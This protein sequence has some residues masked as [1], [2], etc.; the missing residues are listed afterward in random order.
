MKFKL[1]DIVTTIGNAGDDIP[2]V[3]I[4]KGVDGADWVLLS[5]VELSPGTR[6]ALA[7][8]DEMCLWEDRY[9]YVTEDKT[10]EKEKSIKNLWGLL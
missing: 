10:T 3:V 6:F 7:D 4:A 1:H 2:M 5:G 8:E 9:K